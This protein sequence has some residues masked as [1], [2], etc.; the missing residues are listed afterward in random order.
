MLTEYEKISSRK[1]RERKYKPLVLEDRRKKDKRDGEQQGKIGPT[2]HHYRRGSFFSLSTSLS[3][4]VCRCILSQNRQTVDLV[5][6]YGTKDRLHTGPID[7]EDIAEK[8][9]K[10]QADTSAFQ[11]HRIE[12]SSDQ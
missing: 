5:E 4:C 9:R 6:I 3:H 12:S 1:K 2:K 7:H 8:D 11:Y 10:I